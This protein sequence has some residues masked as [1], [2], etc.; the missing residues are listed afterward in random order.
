[1]DIRI[2][3]VL[4]ILHERYAGDLD[5]EELAAVVGLSR[6]RLEHL[7]RAEAGETIGNVVR[8]LRLRRAAELL[9]TT[10]LSVKEIRAAAG[11][12]DASHFVR[13][14][15]RAYALSPSDYRQRYFRVG[16]GAGGVA[17]DALMLLSSARG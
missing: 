2:R 1:M 14:F 9:V 17:G 8:S 4:S 5:V 3:L 12:Q 10:F 11:W 6:S 13:S 7:F 15:R 16:R